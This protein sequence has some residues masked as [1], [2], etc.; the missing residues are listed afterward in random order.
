MIDLR[1][2]GMPLAGAVRRNLIRLCLVAAVAWG[3]H[4]GFSWARSRLGADEAA[5]TLMPALSIGLLAL[6]AVLIAVPFVPG[7]EIGLAL[8]A[9]EGSTIA[10]WIYLATLCGLTLA[11]AAGSGLPY[12]FLQR[13]LADLRLVRACNLLERLEPL[14]RDARLAL[15]AHGAPTWLEPV[16]RFRHLMLALLVNVPGNA[17]L[18]GGGGILFLAGFSRLFA[19]LPTIATLAVAV[20]PVPLLVWSFGV[21][22]TVWLR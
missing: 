16:T 6:Y 2:V 12:A 4:L 20:A 22:P 13:A 17:V 5:E 3:L 21:D 14:D 19:P 9:M 15:L 10:P 7:L 8:M 18:G 1:G 11:F